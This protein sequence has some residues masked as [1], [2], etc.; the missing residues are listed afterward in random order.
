LFLVDD[1]IIQYEP[2]LKLSFPTHFRFFAKILKKPKTAMD[3]QLKH[4][5][6]YVNNKSR[7]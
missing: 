6:Q 4:V 2:Y 1:A 7:G 5:Y 3:T